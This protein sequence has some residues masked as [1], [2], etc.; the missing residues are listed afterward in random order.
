MTIIIVFSKNNDHWLVDL[1]E[2]L[3]FALI[4]TNKFLLFNLF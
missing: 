4:M 1:E 3:F 2:L